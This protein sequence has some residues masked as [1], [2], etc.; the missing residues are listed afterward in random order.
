MNKAVQ[1]LSAMLACGLVLTSPAALALRDYGTWSGEATS[2][3]AHTIGVNTVD[4][5]RQVLVSAHVA[6]DEM[7]GKPCIVTV[8]T[9]DQRNRIYGPVI[10]RVLA[11]AGHSA[12][13]EIRFPQGLDQSSQLDPALRITVDPGAASGCH[14]VVS[15]HGDR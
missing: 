2:T 7:P 1:P 9:F 13:Q 8:R 6:A 12:N 11:G 4:T 10:A 14:W 3:E 5:V 15:A